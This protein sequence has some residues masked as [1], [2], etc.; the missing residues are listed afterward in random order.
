MSAKALDVGVERGGRLLLQQASVSVAPGELTVLVGPNGAGKSTLLRT[1]SGELRP[2]QGQVLLWDRPLADWTAL[3]LATRRAVV[4]QSAQMAFPWVVRD[5]VAL[6][7]SPHR[8]PRQVD[9]AL[10]KHALRRVGVEHLAERV[11]TTLSGGELQRV[12]IARALTQLGFDPDHPEALRDK[13]LF[14]DE[15]TASLDP[16]HQHQVLTLARELAEAGIGVL[17]IVHDLAM[18]HRYAHRVLVLAAGRVAFDGAPEQALS[19][20][21]VA[22]IFH[23]QAHLL[24][25]PDSQH[26]ALSIQG[27]LPGPSREPNEGTLP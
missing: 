16:V 2:S 23:V 3:E 8:T 15:P 12:Q 25:L 1:L 7:R 10:V 4:A 18:A 27:P 21:R 9:D 22:A 6:G 5:L 11:S 14:L 13:L 20:A 24:A 26:L 17:C 19:P